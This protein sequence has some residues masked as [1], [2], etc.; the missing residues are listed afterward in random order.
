MLLLLMA[1]PKL[2]QLRVLSASLIV[3][4]WLNRDPRLRKQAN[5][6]LQNC[7]ML[8]ASPQHATDEGE[9]L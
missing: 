7:L 6:A 8:L 5:K 4:V 3:I 9:V 2:F 1:G